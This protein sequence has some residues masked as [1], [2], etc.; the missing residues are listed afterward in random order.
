[1][2][3]K[4]VIIELNANAC[5]APAVRLGFQIPTCLGQHQGGMPFSP[6]RIE[7]SYFL[8]WIISGEGGGQWPDSFW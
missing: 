7:A 2:N 5:R 3:Q 8:R 6:I 1:M 4:E